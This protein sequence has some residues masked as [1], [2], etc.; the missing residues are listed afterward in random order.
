MESE[1]HVFGGVAAA[2][3]F[4]EGTDD[5]LTEDDKGV[6]CGDDLGEITV[7]RRVNN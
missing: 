4:C 6:C 1:V 5:C 3:Y 2:I 7:K